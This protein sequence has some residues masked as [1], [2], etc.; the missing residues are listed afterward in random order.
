MR[1]L[2]FQDVEPRDLEMVYY[3]IYWNP[4]NTKQY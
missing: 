3:L 1:I 2:I 4:F